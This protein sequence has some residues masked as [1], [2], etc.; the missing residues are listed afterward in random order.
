MSDW[1][2]LWK[3]QDKDIKNDSPQLQNIS[4]KLSTAPTTEL[5]RLQDK[6]NAKVMLMSLICYLGLTHQ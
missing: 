5:T 3:Y 2:S 4:H 6:E 1:K